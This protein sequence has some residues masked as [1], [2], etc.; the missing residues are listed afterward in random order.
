MDTTAGRNRL[1]TVVRT[2]AVEQRAE[3]E[4]LKQEASGLARPDFIW[5]Y[6]LQSFSTMG[7]ASGWRGLIGNQDNYRRV[8]YPVLAALSPEARQQQVQQ[9][10][11]AANIRMPDRKA[12][13]ILGCFDYIQRLGGLETAKSRLL[14]E[15]GRD[16]KIRFLQT[17]PGIGPKYARNIMMDVYHEDFRDSI[18]LDVR[19]LAISETLGLSFPSY[20][21]HEEF[22]L[23]VAS[24]AGLNG[25]ELDRLLFNFRPVVEARLGMSELQ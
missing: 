3:L 22:Y 19:I 23:G 12:K 15:C 2:L 17:F 18:A 7:R 11:R 1:V 6:L 5:H 10:C 14:S 24:E 13:F 4:R 9:T 25:W 8:T 21:A 16:G 20:A